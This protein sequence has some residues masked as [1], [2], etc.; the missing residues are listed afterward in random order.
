VSTRLI[1]LNADLTRLRH[2]G[3][4]IEVRGGYLLV[5]NVPYVAPGPV[6][7]VSTLVCALDQ[8]DGITQRPGVHTVLF[9]GETPCNERG[10]P[11][12]SVI[13]DSNQNDLGDGLVARHRLSSKPA[14]GHY[15]DFHQKMSQ[16][17]GILCGYAAKL[18]PSVTATPFNPV[19]PDADEDTVFL[20]ADTASSR[21]EITGLTPKLKLPKV[22]IVGTGGTGGYV[23]DFL[24]KTEI[25]EIH[26]YDGDVVLQHNAFR[27]PGAA[28]KEQLKGGPMKA[29]Q[30][31]EQYSVLRKGIV[32]HTVRIDE[33]NVE[34]LREMDFVFVAVDHAPSRRMIAE[35]LT[36]FGVPF[37]DV[38]MGLELVDGAITGQIRTVASTPANREWAVRRIPLQGDSAMDDYQR[39]IQVV[40]LNALN[41]AIAVI[42]WKKLMGFYAHPDGEM[43]TVFQVDGQI[44]ITETPD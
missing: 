10:E 42:M 17:A 8:T 5:K 27:V 16:Y 22:A 7:K 39:N 18:D 3:Y 28:S 25:C 30:L 44:V 6:V 33:S 12:Q 43:S 15:D 34:R 37:I 32:A 24:A 2:E 20:Y 31:A 41:A 14:S 9:T 35:K 26:L 4:D 40:E 36:D 19:E 21:A 1:S 38:G 23:L 11:L 13:A 29:R